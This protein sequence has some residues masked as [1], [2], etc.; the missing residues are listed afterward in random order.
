[1]IIDEFKVDDLLADCC[2]A[3][4]LDQAILDH[5]TDGRSI[6]RLPKANDTTKAKITSHGEVRYATND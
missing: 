5:M 6:G 4:Q 3:S 1:M 2:G